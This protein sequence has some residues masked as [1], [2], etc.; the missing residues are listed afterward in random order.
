MA[1][2][3]QRRHALNHQGVGSVAFDLGS[4]APQKTHQIAYLGLPRYISQYAL[5]SRENRCH[6]GILCAANRHSVEGKICPA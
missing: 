3:T 4:H 6:D 1:G 2:T 5:T